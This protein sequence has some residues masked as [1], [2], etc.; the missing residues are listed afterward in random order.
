M[1]IFY[2]HINYFSLLIIIYITIIITGNKEVSR[3][4]LSGCSGSSC[5]IYRGKQ[6]R[7]TADFV[8]NQNTNKAE[9]SI[10]GNVNG[11]VIAI[12]GTDSNACNYV[13]SCPLV[14]GQKYTFDYPLTVLKNLPVVKTV[15]TAKVIGD[16][17]VLACIQINGDIRD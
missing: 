17:G 11:L 4:V 16:N 1:M 12:P 10:T 2:D 9:L 14:K 7:M 8:A 6:F 3:L 5:T 13:K 15:L